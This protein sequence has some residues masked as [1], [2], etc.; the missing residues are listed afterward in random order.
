MLPLMILNVSLFPSAGLSKSATKAGF[1]IGAKGTHTS[2]TMMLDELRQVFAATRFDASREDY[3]AA[4][5]D[6]NCLAKPTVATRRL[7]NQRLGEVYG[8]DL[9]LPV[10]RVLRRL[11]DADPESRPLLALLVSVA[12]D[13]LLAATVQ[14]IV[15]LPV[16]A[17]FGRDA[18]RAALHVVVGGRLNESTLEKVCRNV[19]STWAQA[20]HLEGRTFK[21]RR[22][23]NPTASSAAM[24]IYLA[25]TAGF[26]GA[27]IF[28]SAWLRLLDSDP[29]RARHLA[30]DAK[31]LG[32]ID[33][34]MAGDIVELNLSRL[35]PPQARVA[36]GAH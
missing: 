24:A 21:R 13:P 32:L 31:R 16:N 35:D 14:S 29:S 12:R 10:F 30:L 1:R 7:T 15:S 26:R 3:A 5:I 28:E 19:A 25:H 34:R 9:A 36:H 4:I 11:W 18:V 23:V 6:G 33:L 17:E 8:L 2:R 27:E 20:G 22:S